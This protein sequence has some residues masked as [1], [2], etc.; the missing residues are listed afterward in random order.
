[1]KTEYHEGFHEYWTEFS[2]LVQELNMTGKRPQKKKQWFS[3]KVGRCFI[4]KRAYV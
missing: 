2:I 3:G 4:C 1:M